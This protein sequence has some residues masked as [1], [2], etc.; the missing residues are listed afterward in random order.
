MPEDAY[1]L[2]GQCTHFKQF[3]V[4]LWVMETNHPARKFYEKLGARNAGIVD[5]TNPAGGGSAKNCGYDL[6]QRRW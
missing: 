6:A 3:G 4:Y 5:K 2:E 1:P